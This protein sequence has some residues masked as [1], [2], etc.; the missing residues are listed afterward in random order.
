MD[1]AYIS[2]FAALAGSIVGG[3]TSLAT[4]WLGQRTQV[5]ADERIRDRRRREEVYWE[6]HR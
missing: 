4:S 5:R 2:A 3:L 6:I 1:G